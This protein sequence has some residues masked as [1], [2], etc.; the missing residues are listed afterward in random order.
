MP[1]DCAVTPLIVSPSAAQEIHELIA[2]GSW[3][4]GHCCQLRG[5]PAEWKLLDTSLHHSSGL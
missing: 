3:Y 5:T 1:H 4:T 2:R